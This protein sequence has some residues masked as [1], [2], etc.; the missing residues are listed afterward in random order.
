MPYL[1]RNNVYYT[2]LLFASITWS[3]SGGLAVGAYDTGNVFLDVDELRPGMKGYGKTVFSGDKIEEFDVEIL[4]VLKN[5]ETK[6]DMIL[7]KLSG[8]PLEKTGVISGMS[9]SPVYVEDKVIGAV[10]YGWGFA[11]E[12]IAGVTPIKEMLKVLEAGE[13]TSASGGPGAKKGEKEL[14]S[15]PGRYMPPA[16]WESPLGPH[17]MNV[18]E[19]LAREGWSF[20][21]DPS[22]QPIL[23][24]VPIKTPLMV[25]GFDQRVLKQMSEGLERY[26]LFPVQGGGVTPHGPIPMGD[27]TTEVQGFNGSK[28]QMAGPLTA[29]GGQAGTL[30]I[31]AENMAPGAAIAT[32]LS[33]GD[34]NASAVGTL[35]Y[36]LGDSILAF[37]HPFIQAGK[38]DIP[39]AGA[40][41][42]A[43]IPIQSTSLKLASP[44]RIMGRIFQDSKAALAGTLG[45]FSALI[46]C[47]IKVAGNQEV[48]YNFE[49][50]KD[51]FLT[52]NLIQ[53]ASESALLATERQAGDKTVRLSLSIEMEGRDRP[54]KVENIYYEPHPTWF[55]VY[56]ITQP[57]A[58]IMNNPFQEASIKRISLEA[59]VSD[60]RRLAYIEDIKVETRE[61]GPG[62]TVQ[63]FVTIRPFGKEPVVITVPLQ[64]P[65]DVSPG[66]TITVD[67]CNADTSQALER[68]RAPEKFLPTSLEHLI[69]IL[70]DAEPNTNLIVRAV[71]PKRGITY[72]GKPLPSLPSS[73]LSIMSFP[74]QSGI[75]RLTEELV[76]K[77]PVDWILQ[78]S[79]NFTLTVKEGS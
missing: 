68:S 41:V 16:V 7:V 15:A 27:E 22:K 66:S 10:S 75:G 14:A 3:A 45:Q 78:G 44:T 32:I 67:A 48:E 51:R 40:H 56:H 79:Q 64:I 9:G 72:R 35:T 37:G 18:K 54:V 25:G 20:P 11:K 46:P 29:E 62:E 19:A 23:R 2:I 59:K 33:R 47:T 31:E 6:N 1:N 53:W 36:R 42:H 69:K 65:L 4:G 39:L 73:L 21:S 24:M 13:A 26:G 57:I 76:S 5:W 58:L 70:E 30:Q 34:I 8:G 52:Q 17:E 74:N 55:P 49:V 43:V 71:L 12:A 77:R 38:T 61:V 50:V 28:V 60:E 63:L